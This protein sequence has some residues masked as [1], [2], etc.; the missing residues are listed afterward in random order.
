[1]NHTITAS[2]AV[3]ILLEAAVPERTSEFRELWNTYSPTVEIATDTPG[4]TL[5]ANKRR[6]LFQHKALDVLWIIG[7]SAWESIATYSP[8][9]AIA[10]NTSKRLEDALGN[11]DGRGELEMH[12]KARLAAARDIIESADTDPNMWP[13]DVPQPGL[14]RSTASIEQ[15]SAYDLTLL[16]T[17]F[18][19]FH[20]FRHVMLDQDGQRPDDPAE[21]ELLCDTWAREFMTVK[22]A[23]YA[24]THGHSYSQVL[25]KRAAA[26]ALGSLMLHEITPIAMHG[27]VPSDYPPFAARIRAISG[28]MT[29]P[30]DSTYWIYAGCLLVGALRRQ[31]RTLDIVTN[32]PRELVNLLI[33]M[34]D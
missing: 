21:E 27:G 29:L 17:A 33:G 20:E 23:D 5:N 32:S 1:M 6:I 22:L 15:A 25:N 31:H 3:R 28:G 24:Q 14:N 4:F 34:F 30:E 11:D 2:H 8:A 19:L 10:L 12:Y 16:A 7:F 18:V 13:N 26:M 9:I